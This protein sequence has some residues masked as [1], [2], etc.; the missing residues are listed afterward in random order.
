MNVNFNTIPDDQIKT[1]SAQSRDVSE[2]KKAEGGKSFPGYS[3][4]IGNNNSPIIS[5]KKKSVEELIEAGSPA[6][7]KNRQD[8][9]IL[10]SNTVSPEAYGKM[11]EEGFDPG[12]LDPKDAV[13]IVDEIKATMAKSGVVIA[14]YNDDLS[15][16]QLEAIT[17]SAAYAQEIARSFE[18]QGVPLNEENAKEAA[19]AVE[20]LVSMEPLDDSAKAYMVENGMQPTPDALYRAAHSG[21]GAGHPGAQGYVQIGAYLS[22]TAAA[23]AAGLEQ[24]KGQME[25][26]IERAGEEADESNIALAEQMVK[27]GLPL[28]EENFL[29]MKKLDGLKLPMS[30]ADAADKAAMA[31][32]DGIHPSDYDISRDSTLL[33]EAVEL[34]D[35][36]AGIKDEAVDRAV[37]SELP[38]N[39]KNLSR[40]S[41]TSTTISVQISMEA[42]T[43]TAR[44]QLEE[45]RLSMTVQVSYHMLKAGVNVDT[46]E[47]SDLVDKL[48]SAEQ[49]LLGSR[50]NTSDTN[51]AVS[52]AG[53]F[54]RTIDS[55][56]QIPGMPV[57][58]LGDFLK[59]SS[60][61][62]SSLS[63]FASA[64]ASLK[65]QYQAAGIS[66]ETM[67]TQVR[68]DLGDN[69]KK[70]FSHAESLLMELHMESSEENLRATRILGYNS[71]EINMA[72]IDRIKEA[73]GIV[74]DIMERMTPENTLQMI[75]DGVNPLKM[76]MEELDDYLVR[77]GKSG[78]S[79][80]E[81]LVRMEQK[82]QITAEERESYIG[83]Y[84]MLHQVQ[85]RDGAAVGTLVNQERELSFENLLSAVR[86]RKSAGM[87]VSVDDALES[88]EGNNANDIARQIETAMYKEAKRDLKEAADVPVE[89]YG[90]LI[91]N[92][93][94]ADADSLLGIKG[95]RERRGE[96]F[97]LS[98]RAAGAPHRRQ[99]TTA[100]GR[101]VSEGSAGGGADPFKLTEDIVD[102]AL[103]DACAG[104]LD[105]FDSEADA[106]QAYSH[107]ADV[108]ERVLADAAMDPDGTIDLRAIS[109]AM[110]QLGTARALANE[111]SY[112]V[113]MELHGEQTAVSVRIRHEEGVRGRV[114]ISMESA[115]FGNMHAAFSAM[116]TG[117]DI[118][119]V[120]DSMEGRD[121]AQALESTL[122]AR[123]EEAG[124]SI[125]AC[126]FAYSSH[127]TLKD[128]AQKADDNIDGFDTATL[129]R[130]AKIFLR[131]LGEA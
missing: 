121:A 87:D 52:R 105:N 42:R 81:F 114:D 28:T 26:L 86:S 21:S 36:A 7:A 19:A 14:G 50:Y 75:R 94:D 83:V 22:K 76:S 60:D 72:N 43:V 110:K 90:E 117:L 32:S 17:G 35:K 47:L 18:Q 116:E 118:Y 53:I 74:D 123:Y 77:N 3:L 65:L 41:M 37:A 68:S 119:A 124:I 2:A 57:S 103:E 54:D 30:V 48:K 58:L 122:R 46:L 104:V 55:L 128:R 91:Q 101:I 89:L 33:E 79:Y 40:L 1:A 115:Y 106:K 130:S 64:G 67:Q 66:Y 111:E 44:R 12:K 56:R 61:S 31:L 100:D 71:M 78:E 5:D 34:S 73:C 99:H 82:N 16:E 96:L 23:D 127:F 70:A 109:S 88:V 62:F 63:S 80:S 95:L 98:R 102:A 6:D 112:E 11:Q 49:E 13:N 108:A 27:E 97:D 45:V 84:R 39:L 25:K 125:Y 15:P 129:Y 24:L 59:D 9:M 8:M 93:L 10:M 120:T 69:I 20:K 38:M 92:G 29:L 107:M 131:T 113:P 51:E 4:D 85:S 126:N